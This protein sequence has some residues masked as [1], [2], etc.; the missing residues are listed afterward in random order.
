MVPLQIGWPNSRPP[1]RT[2]TIHLLVDD[3]QDAC[4]TCPRGRQL[5]VTL[6]LLSFCVML[7]NTSALHKQPSGQT[8]TLRGCTGTHRGHTTRIW[9]SALPQTLANTSECSVGRRLTPLR[10]Y[11]PHPDMPFS[12]PRPP[13]PVWA[14]LCVGGIASPQLASLHRCF[15]RS[16]GQGRRMSDEPVGK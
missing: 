3:S 4:E 15:Q 9:W 11:R 5:W 14:L 6:T 1:L 13:S 12:D 8:K 16:P 7:R 2:I 10:S